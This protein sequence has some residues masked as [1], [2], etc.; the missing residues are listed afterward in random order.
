VV[1]GVSAGGDD[2]YL[3]AAN[4]AYPP[5]AVTTTDA[6]GSNLLVRRN[7]QGSK[8][9]I[10]NGLLRWNTAN[11]LPANATVVAATLRLF[12]QGK[13]DNNNRALI[14][15]W[16][17]WGATIDASDY[18]AA[19]QSTALSPAGACGATCNLTSIVVNADNNFTLDN[20]A[21]VNVT[22]LTYLRL[23]ISGGTPSAQNALTIASF[24]NTTLPEPRLVIDYVAP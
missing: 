21:N 19:A 3:E 14:A 12:V 1:C 13:N 9:R 5:P 16:Y 18:Q 4:A 24:D 2:G 6:T 17:N 22:G 15:D 8:Y 10:A 23:H 11:C 7:L 20:V